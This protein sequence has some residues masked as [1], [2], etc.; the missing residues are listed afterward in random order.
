MSNTCID[1]G[2]GPAVLDPEAAGSEVEHDGGVLE[3]P[4]AQAAGFGFEH[5]VGVVGQDVDSDAVEGAVADGE[6]ADDVTAACH[7]AVLVGEQGFAALGENAEA[8]TELLEGGLLEDEPAAAAVEVDLNVAAGQGDGH[9]QPPAHVVGVLADLHGVGLPSL[10]GRGREGAVPGE[11]DGGVGVIKAD[12]AEAGEH[13]Q[14][15]EDGVLLHQGDAADVELQVLGQ[16]KAG[17]IAEGQAADGEGGQ[18]ADAHAAG[19][20]FQRVDGDAVSADGGVGD[21][22]GQRAAGVHFDGHGGPVGQAAVDEGVVTEGVLEGAE[23]DAHG[24]SGLDLEGGPGDA[25]DLQVGV[26]GV[27]IV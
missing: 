1:G 23:G 26:A 3:L 9:F 22:H 10:G 7:G 14:A 8:G 13:G 24:V 2:L 4:E 11:G 19:L 27:G 18:V 15:Q 12:V 17:G 6:V 25:G 16:E 5:V 20:V 21:D